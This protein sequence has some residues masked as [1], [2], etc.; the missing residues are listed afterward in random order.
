[1][2]REPPP[3][4]PPQK[5]D[6]IYNQYFD[7]TEKYQKIYGQNTI[8]LMQ[9]GSFFEVYGDKHAKTGQITKSRIELFK[10]TCNLMIA[11]KSCQTPTGVL[12]M[13]G[14][15][16]YVLDKYLE[17]MTANGITAVVFVQ[18]KD[19]TNGGKIVREF[20]GVYSPGTYLPY[21]SEQT[22]HHL[23]NNLMCIWLETAT[24]KGTK[25]MICGMANAHI[26]TGQTS[27]FEYETPFL[28]NTTTFDELERYISVYNPSE[29][30]LISA[31][32]EP[33]TQKIVNELVG[34]KPQVLHIIY[35]N[36]D[37]FKKDKKTSDEKNSNKENQ[38]LENCQNQ[39]YIQHV[40][41]ALFGTE[42]FQLCQE[43]STYTIATQAFVYLVHFLQ[44]HSPDMAKR[45]AI[46][47]F[48][49]TSTRMILANH[50][51][52]QL[53]VLEDLSDDGKKM[54]KLSS[55]YTWLN[56]CCTP[57]GK[58]EYHAQITS[59]TFDE[60]WLNK[61]YET[62]SLFIKNVHTGSFDNLRQNLRKICDMEKIMRQLILRK[63]Y[64]QT[65][66]SF[67]KS[68]CE[69]SDLLQHEFC[70]IDEATTYLF[71]E[72]EAT[73]KSNLNKCRQF[74]ETTLNIEK[75]AQIASMTSFDH[76]IISVGISPKLDAIFT[77]YGES[78]ATF[79][80]VHRHF[81]E[82]LGE[83][84]FVKIHETEKMGFS[85][86]ITKKRGQ[87]LLTVLEKMK[88]KTLDIADNFIIPVKDVRLSK[89]TASNEEL[90]FP[91]LKRLIETIQKCKERMSEEIAAAYLV[92]LGTF[93]QDWFNHCQSFVK[94]VAKLDV[95]QCKAYVAKKYNYCKPV[96]DNSA[97]QSFFEFKGLR[98][99][100][101]EHIQTNEIYVTND[102]TM[103][104]NVSIFESMDKGIVPTGILLY[105]TNAVGKT[106]F[107]RA[108]GIAIIMAQSGF[109][110]PCSEFCYKPYTAIYTRIL[111]NDNLFKNLSTFAVEM[112]E[113]R[114]ILNMADEN[115]LILGDELCSGTETESALSIF[116]AGLVT[117]HSRK[118][119]FLFATHFHEIAKWDE[120]REL[121]CLQMKHMSV[122]YDRERDCLVYDRKLKDGAGNRMYGLEVCKS[123][124]LDTAFLEMAYG[125]RNR[126]FDGQSEL[127]AAKIS[128]YNSKKVRGLCEI[129]KEVMGQETHHLSPQKDADSEGFIGTFHKNHPANLSSVCSKCHDKI[130]IMDNK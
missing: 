95:L 48:K 11:E 72:E 116:S 38:I 31:F 93:E 25:H 19:A 65:F 67:Y 123:L 121:N 128:S 1:M 45:L 75:C 91:Q 42:S 117:L 106:S 29:V 109:Y 119:T 107:I 7:Y 27:I 96:I 102:L 83:T 15:R 3:I 5:E 108:I 60:Q 74:I 23:S 46:P 87:Q 97:P 80:K 16:D 85:L 21:E 13:A 98:H 100:L 30:I 115:S 14:F 89:S 76:N 110:V 112:S 88:T 79:H 8:V 12:V 126:Y 6:L 86:I 55:I 56:R 120:I 41:S 34:I 57:M 63:V 81:N 22:T 36:D 20:A 35:S 84:D 40:L 73:I 2:Y 37:N 94:F 77:E 127:A 130:H 53:N 114:V 49:N 113:L 124:Y 70:C 129:C 111:G 33:T 18:K 101:I 64:P 43:F 90:D 71:G 17:K 39:V 125:F 24:I 105:G 78:L 26:F 54:G 47:L 118:S 122:H 4:M 68:L 61:E 10:S 28:L 52:K 59:P 58:R 103:S 66:Y 82:I 44:E 9:V 51:L 99:V 104:K 69:I 92:F 62:T 32:N 50:T